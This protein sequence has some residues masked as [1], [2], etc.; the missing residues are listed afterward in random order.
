MLLDVALALGRSRRI[1][2]SYVQKGGGT[3]G[4]L[5]SDD[6]GAEWRALRTGLRSETTEP[7]R[8]IGVGEHGGVWVALPG[9]RVVQWRAL[10]F[11]ERFVGVDA[12]DP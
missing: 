12:I 4:V 11:M 2:V 6:D 3:H 10:S 9:G 8:L 1:A 5:V 7:M